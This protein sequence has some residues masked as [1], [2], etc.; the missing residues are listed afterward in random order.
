MRMT[1]AQALLGFTKNAAMALQREDIGSLVVGAA[2]DFVIH[3]VPGY[4]FLPYR[5]GGHYVEKV[6]KRGREVFS[7]G[8]S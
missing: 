7:S 3:S 1:P 8:R 6:F 4:R 2:A 5:I